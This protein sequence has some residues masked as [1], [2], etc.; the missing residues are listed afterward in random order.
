MESRGTWA[1][2]VISHR[3]GCNAIYYRTVGLARP[4]DRSPVRRRAE[5]GTQPLAVVSAPQ[6]RAA[7]KA[8]PDLTRSADI[9]VNE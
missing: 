3:A 6:S 5:R 2:E 1:F 7:S 9:Q 4:R 8:V